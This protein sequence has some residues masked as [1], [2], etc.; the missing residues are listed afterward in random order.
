MPSKSPRTL[1]SKVKPTSGSSSNCK[2]KSLPKTKPLSKHPHYLIVDTM[3]ASHVFND[4]FLFM[5]YIP[6]RWLHWTVFG[7]DI[8]IEVNGDIHICVIVSGKSII[9]CFHNSWHVPSS[10]H[11]FLSSS[12]AISLGNQIVIAGHAPRMIFSHQKCLVKPNFPKDMPFT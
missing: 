11:H 3:L 1:K 10:W 12:T 8:V 5:T 2:P 7:T 9:F 6:S 4:H